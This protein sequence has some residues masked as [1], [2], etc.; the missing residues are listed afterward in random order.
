MSKKIDEYEV[1]TEFN[2]GDYQKVEYT[3]K[4]DG[5]YYFFYLEQDGG[6]RLNTEEF[7]QWLQDGT[8]KVIK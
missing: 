3:D 2:K 4:K 1:G 7:S 8:L 6:F 5:L